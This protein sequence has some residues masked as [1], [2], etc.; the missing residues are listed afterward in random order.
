M[1]VTSLDVMPP[2]MGEQP[3]PFQCEQ[4]PTCFVV[5][6]DLLDF[7]TGQGGDD[8]VLVYG[9]ACA[10]HTGDLEAWLSI[11]FGA[12]TAPY[13]VHVLRDLQTC[14][15]GTYDAAF[16]VVPLPDAATA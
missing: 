15:D 7:V 11:P 8:V 2:C 14:L 12:F 16:Q 4:T 6:V 5:G 13:E 3:R 1:S 9:A 10:E